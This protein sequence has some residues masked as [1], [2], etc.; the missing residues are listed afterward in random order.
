VFIKKHVKS[1][2]FA[3]VPHPHSLD[4]GTSSN[5][6]NQKCNW[7]I[8]RQGDYL[9][10]TW[11][12][13]GLS[14]VTS[15]STTYSGG[16]TGLY[17]RWCHN[18]AHNLIESIQLTFTGIPGA[19][20]D[21]FFLDFFSAFTVPAGKRNAYDNMIGN[22]PELVNPIYDY[23]NASAVQR[24]PAATLNL[25]IPLPY[26]R[27]TGI[28]LPAST[29]IYN[30]VLVEVDFRD[31]T[32]CL[33]VSNAR[34]VTVSS[35]IAHCSR[36]AT[37]SDVAAAPTLSAA[38]WGTYAVVTTDERKRMG[39]TQRDVIWEVA[40]D[41]NTQSIST[42]STSHELPLRYSHA[43]KALLFGVENITVTSDHSNYTTREPFCRFAASSGLTTCEFPSPLAFDPIERVSLMYE[44]AQR[45]DNMPV[46][47]FAL[48]Q[49]YYFTRS[50]PTITGYHMYSFSLDLSDINHLGSVDFGKLTNV[51]LQ[52]IHSDDLVDALAGS[53]ANTRFYNE[54]GV[55]SHLPPG[56][57]ALTLGTS[58]AKGKAQS[59]QV[60]S[61]ALSHTAARFIGGAVGFPIF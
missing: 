8:G 51:S 50:A 53:T 22:I 52:L 30:D 18:L 26:T 35:V 5:V 56:Y 7:K 44:G 61:A 47:Y 17:L 42:S 2:W 37:S 32:E 48:V 57:A 45:L 29:L 15:S 31:Y 1:N 16:A 21:S 14:A 6:F 19:K 33:V 46:D 28:A 60:R 58:G 9:T 13:L 34:E 36:N 20:M 25:P 55:A 54:L 10:H 12:R 38:L 43:V 3:L 24:L 27:E 49:P 11:L 59:F 4:A 23:T 39:K 40:Q 41:Q